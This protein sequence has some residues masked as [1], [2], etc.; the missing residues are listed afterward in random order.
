MLEVETANRHGSLEDYLSREP[1]VEPAQPE[2]QQPHQ[3]VILSRLMNDGQGGARKL[4]TH[5]RR[6][7][8]LFEQQKLMEEEKTASQRQQRI[9]QAAVERGTKKLGGVYLR[10]NTGYGSDDSV[11][12][13]SESG[14]HNKTSRSSDNFGALEPVN[15]AKAKAER[16]GRRR[17]HTPGK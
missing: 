10:A 2:K 17:F 7:D 16:A 8:E 11:A 9:K 5:V 15:S 6:Q 14:D 3:E 12:Q 13:G 4:S 1:D